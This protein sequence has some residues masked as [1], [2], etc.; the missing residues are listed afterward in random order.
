MWGKILVMYNN[1]NRLPGPF[2][3]VLSSLSA[4]LWSRINPFLELMI[5]DHCF[6]SSIAGWLAGQPARGWIHLWYL[7]GELFTIADTCAR[8]VLYVLVRVANLV[9]SLWLMLFV[10]FHYSSASVW[11]IR[12]VTDTLCQ[13]WPSPDNL[14]PKIFPSYLP[15]A[16]MYIISHRKNAKKTWECMV[17]RLG[18]GGANSW[19]VG[20]GIIM[21]TLNLVRQNTEWQPNLIH[22]PIYSI[23]WIGRT[24]YNTCY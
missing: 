18:W 1:N 19:L 5:W 14:F 9:L 3:H 13:W 11:S 21:S 24:I 17:D 6:P 12:T 23:I 10:Y 8:M 22:S 7:P 20:S 4:F 2:P 16:Q 15:T